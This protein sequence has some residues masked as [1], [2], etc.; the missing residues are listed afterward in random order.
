MFTTGWMRAAGD[1]GDVGYTL[2]SPRRIVDEHNWPPLVNDRYVGS[3]S[4][5]K[6]LCCISSRLD[7]ERSRKPLRLLSPVVGSI[8][9]VKIVHQ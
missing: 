2:T 3:I 9:R 4:Y 1:A 5:L 8:Q 7:Y 6:L